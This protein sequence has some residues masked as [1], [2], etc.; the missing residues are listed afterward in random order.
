MV[1]VALPLVSILNL[2][3]VVSPP[4]VELSEYL[5]P[6]ECVD[7]VWDEGKG[8]SIVNCVLVE[9]PTY[10]PDKGIVCCPS[11]WQRRRVMPGGISRS[12]F[13]WILDVC[14][15]TCQWL[16]IHQGREGRFSWFSGQRCRPYWSCDHKSSI[17]EGFQ[18][19]VHW[20]PSGRR[21]TQVVGWFRASWQQ[22]PQVQVLGR[23]GRWR[24][25][26]GSKTVRTINTNSEVTP[27]F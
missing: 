18:Q 17:E 20:R 24:L 15:W 26:R 27:E 6:L 23:L 22:L 7:G 25:L 3:I 14:Q 1:N 4:D 5:H 12:E 19:S 8:I 16:V 13:F 9:V 10:N 2:H 11:F 21:N